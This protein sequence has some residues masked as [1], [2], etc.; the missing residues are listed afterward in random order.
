[1]PQDT[2]DPPTADEPAADDHRDDST[3]GGGTTDAVEAAL[4]RVRDPE[5]DT[6]VFEA[7]VVDTIR[8]AD[9][10]A[11]IEADLREFPREAAEGVTQAMVRA[12]TDVDGVE[13]A[14]VEQIDPSPDLDGRDAGIETADRVIAVASSKGGVGKTTVATSLACALAA[15]ADDDESVGLFDADLYGPNVPEFLSVSGPVYSDE[16]GNPVP[17]DA[18]GLE[19]MSVGLLAEGGPLAWRGAMAHDAI[20]DLFE[21]TAWSDPD[22]VVLDLPPGTGDV[23]LTTLQDVPIDGVVLVTT[24]FHAAVSDTG[25]ALQLFEENDV[26]VLGVVSNMGEFVCDDCGT[27]HD[28]FGGD[29][30]VQ[31][32][33]VPVLAEVPFTPEMQADP[34]P[35][36]DA[37]SDHA[38]ALADAVDDRYDDVWTVDV[39]EGGVDLRGLDPDDRKER[40]REGFESLA[41]GEEFYIVSDRDPTPVRGF[42]LELVDADELPGFQVKRQNPETWLA[43]TTRP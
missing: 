39:P 30:P 31:A 10:G 25:R 19:V 34:E 17:V 28:L 20:S 43:R 14:R 21:E 15:E 41:E 5:T 40:V 23:V 18:G 2:P 16:D 33:D 42:L 36:A 27:V 38:L 3:A 37:L 13:K 9:G 7:G 8:V 11:T 29:D 4:R 22:T 35:D 12:A 32:L 26:P 1:M 6:S 24:P